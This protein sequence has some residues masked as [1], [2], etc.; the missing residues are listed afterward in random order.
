MSWVAL[1]RLLQLHHACG[2]RGLNVERMERERERICRAIRERAWNPRLGAY[3]ETLEGD[4]L[5]ANTL[6]LGWYRFEDPRSPRMRSTYEAVRENLGAGKGLLY[7]YRNGDSP[8]EGA[9]AVC[10]F[11][12]AELLASGTGTL[13][14]AEA[15]LEAL[16]A[17]RN[18]VGLMAEEIDPETSAQLGNFPQA[19]SH[20]GLI[21]A[22]ISVEHRR[23]E[24]ERNHELRLA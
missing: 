17:H 9:F 13:E 24:E 7:R 14:E 3:T 2:L 5:D 16:L 10:G 23:A 21:N 11:W 20:I 8:G 18:D 15:M 1:D 19:F 12:A 6:L 4:A 22:A